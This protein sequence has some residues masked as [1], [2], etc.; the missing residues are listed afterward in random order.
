[1]IDLPE[2]TISL[3]SCTNKQKHFYFQ[4]AIFDHVIIN[5]VI[6]SI[7]ESRM[8]KRGSNKAGTYLEGFLKLLD[9]IMFSLLQI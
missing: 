7:E 3:G 2:Q 6:I 9:G 1:M 8:Q 4:A 5:C